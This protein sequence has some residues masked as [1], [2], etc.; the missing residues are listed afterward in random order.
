MLTY[1]LFPA[2]ARALEAF[3]QKALQKL[4]DVLLFTTNAIAFRL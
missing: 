3:F 4:H 2:L 1:Y